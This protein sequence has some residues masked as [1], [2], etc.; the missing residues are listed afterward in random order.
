MARD[1]VARFRSLVHNAAV[2][3]MLVSSSGHIDSVSAALTRML[4]Y[5]PELVENI[6]LADLVAEE[7]RPALGAAMEHA[8]VRCDGRQS[9]DRRGT[10]AAPRC[11]SRRFPSSS[12]S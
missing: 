3:T 4:G 10:P 12:P 9:G 11:A 2:I 7:D 1:E 6:P 8:L 5:D